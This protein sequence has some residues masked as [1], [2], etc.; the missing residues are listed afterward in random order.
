MK[1]L[2]LSAGFGTRLKPYTDVIPKPLF[3]INN[4]PVLGHMIESLLKIGCDHI[5]INTHHLHSQ[6]ESFIHS[7]DYPANIEIV[8][9]PE[10]L[11]TGGAI[12]N[13]KNCY[14]SHPFFVIN[15]DI[16]TNIN[17]K[18]VYEQHLESNPLATL[19][20]H[21]CP[22]FNKVEIDNKNYIQ[23]FQGS[24]NSLAFTGV[25]V[26]SPQ[27]YNFFPPQKN[28]SSIEVY[29]RLCREQQ[30]SAYVEKDIF[31]SDIGTI[32]SYSKTSCRVLAAS[33]F[34]IGLNKI[35]E[36]RIDQL[37][38]DGSDRCWYRA[39]FDEQTI[40]ISDHGICLPRSERL[41]QLN[42]FL[43]IGN[44]LKTKKLPVP[45]LFNYDS[46]SGIVLVEDL[47]DHHLKTYVKECSD[48]SLII[49]MYQKVIDQI[50]LFSNTGLTGFKNEW[51]WQTVEYSKNLILEKECGYFFEEFLL[52]Y[53]NLNI[54]IDTVALDFEVIAQNA[55]TFQ[56]MGL[57]HRDMQSKNI[58][59]HEGSPYFIDFQTARKGPLQYD[60]ASLLI[61]PYVCLEKNIQNLLLDYTIQKLR[62]DS[63]EKDN[64]IECFKYCCVT[65]NLQILGAFSFLS[66]KKNKKEFEQYIPDAVKSLKINIKNLNNPDLNKL[67]ELVNRL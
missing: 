18:K 59:I 33:F 32:E 63:I 61:D 56:H 35:K 7:K 57:I 41:D 50:I 17:L 60:I 46:L 23:N 67:S 65:R 1:A 39:V 22:E 25:Q 53:L 5:I 21:D 36:I 6:I 64:F 42:A 9:E 29:T 12:A 37:A 45:K 49:D 2:I 3:T 54:P 13:T 31:W 58:M 24:V 4:D 19:V 48:N 20:L 44:H 10:I 28:F 26:I 34:K 27:I 52:G 16:I 14:D 30:I 8:Y 40:I 38:G 55:M 15:A 66:Q 43:K 51:A 62:L 47:G 11:E